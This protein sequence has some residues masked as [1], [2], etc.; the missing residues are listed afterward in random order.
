MALP[1]ASTP[2]LVDLTAV[3]SD[4]RFWHKCEVPT[5]SRNVWC[6]GQSGKHLLARS[7]SHFDPELTWGRSCGG[8]SDTA[9]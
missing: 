2:W 1:S 9:F 7:I 6:W 3:L 5:A 8:A 4:V